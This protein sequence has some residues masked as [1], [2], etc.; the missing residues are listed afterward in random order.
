MIILGLKENSI[1]Y[2]NVCKWD[3]Y[4]IELLIILKALNIHKPLI[5]R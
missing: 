5:S 4:D 2:H 3:S 1:Q